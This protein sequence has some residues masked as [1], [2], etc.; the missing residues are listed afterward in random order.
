MWSGPSQNKALLGP[1]IPDYLV[2]HLYRLAAS[3]ATIIKLCAVALHLICVAKSIMQQFYNFIS[4]CV[5]FK[6]HSS[7]LALPVKLSHKNTAHS[8]S[9]YLL[10]LAQF[11]YLATN[12]SSGTDRPSYFSNFNCFWRMVRGSATFLPWL[13]LPLMPWAQSPT[14][15]E[16]NAAGL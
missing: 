15:T 8:S 3:S 4:T 7:W 13:S 1:W 14:T 6:F 10:N 9:V 12:V 16:F 2:H 5:L 11:L